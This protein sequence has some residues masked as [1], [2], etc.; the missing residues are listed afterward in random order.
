MTA[1][2]R[3]SAGGG[4]LAFPLALFSSVRF[5]IVLMSILFVYCSIGSAGVIFPSNGELVY[6]QLRQWRPFEMTEFEWFH[7]W[8]FDLLMV[9]MALNITVTT[10]R[11]IPLKAVNYGVWLIHGGILMMM[12]GCWI[13]FGTK[14]EGDAPVVRRMV[15]AELLGP[16]AAGAQPA[17]VDRATVIASP[18]QR[19][20][21]TDGT[22]RYDLE[23]SSIDPEWTMR[24][25]ESD[26]KRAY[27]VNVMVR[28]SGGAPDDGV[29]AS[30]MRQLLAGYPQH[31]EDVI[32]S[33]D[34]AQPMKRAIK[35]V[36][37]ATVDDG[38]RLSLDFAPAKWFYLRM[39]LE[40][41]WALY[42]RKA[43]DT[44]WTQRP[45]HG[46]PLYNDY[47]GDTS[48]VTQEPGDRPLPADPI[49]VAI[50][51]V[52]NDPFP[53]L[54]LNVSG[55]L[56][57]AFEE[58]LWKDGGAQSP[59]NPR[60]VLRVAA[61]S[62]EQENY[63]LLALDPRSNKG[64]EGVVQFRWAPTEEAYNALLNKPSLRFHVPE[65]ELD[66][67]EP[68]ADV[69]GANADAPFKPIPLPKAAPQDRLYSYRVIAVQDEVGFSTGN[70]SVAIVEIKTPKGSYR[71]WVFSD[72]ALTRDVTDEFLKDPHAATVI[73]DPSIEVQYHP[74]HGKS[75]VT[76]VA[77]PEPER[78]RLISSLG[79][80]VQ[81][82]VIEVGKPVPLSDTLAA[83]VMEYQPRAIAERKPVIVPKA[84]RQRD[85]GVQFSLAR[86]DIPGV[87]SQWFRYHPYVFD[88]PAAVLRRFPFNP[89]TVRLPD[90]RMMEVIFSRQRLG[91]PAN[92]ALDEFVLTSHIGGFTG[93]MG[94]IRDYMSRV[95]FRDTDTSTWTEPVSVSMNAPVE[96]AGLAYFQ[97]QWD[98]P[99]EPRFEGDRG[100]SGLNYTVLGVGNRH[101][102]WT[103]LIGCCISVAGM[104]YAFYVKPIIKR[105]Q[106]EAVYASVAAKGKQAEVA[107]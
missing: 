15:T 87:G 23:I 12:L 100:S 53:D 88:S 41:A 35:A 73:G 89:Q 75:F 106:R 20:S 64:D 91:L 85:A 2:S 101:G 28:R 72:P 52:A 78:L 63:T 70:A 43:G 26:S 22:R 99:D 57:Y 80:R 1:P 76:L 42:V 90:G 45:I 30:F 94:S 32:P 47:V 60:A 8:P 44:E 82:T 83:A 66:V 34:P 46:M 97:S 18:G 103:M 84:Q 37:K 51:P 49:N 93:E 50:P 105:K 98:P 7:W 81:S 36:G 4:L 95:R 62:G 31:T 86:V 21:L 69:A 3:P 71:R 74:G 68:I 17:V 107:A 65:I 14:V 92:I 79:E 6:D 13:Y 33:G 11:R 10:L 24:S 38:L 9:L 104:I 55:Y 19:F 40:K 5:G 29:P 96:Y 54:T 67:T 25:G 58:T 77:G 61:Q 39:E 59:P 48:L 16:A 102:V 56:R 27:S